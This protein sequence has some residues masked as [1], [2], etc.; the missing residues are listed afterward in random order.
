MKKVL[1]ND[2]SVGIA[3]CIKG[4]LSESEQVTEVERETVSVRVGAE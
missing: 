1:R 4:R 3:G 2:L